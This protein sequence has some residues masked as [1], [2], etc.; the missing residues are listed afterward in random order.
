MIVT[1]LSVTVI[2]VTTSGFLETF[3]V[4]LLEPRGQEQCQ[5]DRDQILRDC[6]GEI[7]NL[8]CTNEAD[9]NLVATE[10]PSQGANGAK[11]CCGP[12]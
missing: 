10:C 1:S 9:P 8:Q 2:A 5:A 7:W 4:R 11:Q 6:D 3:A 12:R